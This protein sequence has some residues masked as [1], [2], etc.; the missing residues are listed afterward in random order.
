MSLGRVAGGCIRLWR[1]AS[2]K[3]LAQ[4]PQGEAVVIA[5]GIETALSVAVACPN[6]GCS[7][8]FRWRTCGAW[9]CRR[10]CAPC[11]LC[12]DNDGPNAGAARLFQS[13]VDRF[14]GEGRI[15]KVAV[16]PCGKD[17]NDTLREA[18]A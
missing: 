14:A 1:G 4:A 11:I 5:E 16:P 10:R 17:F 8:L 12:R 2:G 18:G 13:A 7:R 6:C 3:P 9:R 15:V